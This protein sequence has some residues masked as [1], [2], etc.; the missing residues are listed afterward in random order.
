MKKL[1]LIFFITMAAGLQAQRPSWTTQLPSSIGKPFYYRTTSAEGANYDE[2]YS[3]A[4]AKAIEESAWKMGVAVKD[5]T[6][7]VGQSMRIPMN[8]V[9]EY[10]EKLTGRVGVRVYLLWQVARNGISDPDF[11][12]FNNCK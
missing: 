6:Q 7:I 10:E 1:L 8:K 4:F 11:E 3:K 9:C 2:A 12:E 5:G